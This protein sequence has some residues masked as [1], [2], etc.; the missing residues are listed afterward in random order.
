MNEDRIR[1]IAKQASAHAEATV[2]PHWD[3]EDGLDYSAKMMKVRDLKF[4]ELL[5][6]EC[7]TIC[8]AI[9]G[10]GEFKNM[11]DFAAGAEKCK[12][13]IKRDFGVKE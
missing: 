12:A 3:I 8:G 10:A 11:P 2:P 6:K 1:E 4:A 7:M 5:L 9:Q 13:V